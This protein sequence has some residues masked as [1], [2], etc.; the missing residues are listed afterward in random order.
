MSKLIANF[1]CNN[2][3]AM[4][5]NKEYPATHSMSTAWFAADEDGNVAIIDFDENGPVPQVAEEEGCFMSVFM[6]F[7]FRKS[8]KTPI[9]YLNFTKAQVAEFLNNPQKKIKI[10]KTEKLLFGCYVKIKKDEQKNFIKLLSRKKTKVDVYCLSEE[11]SIYYINE[12]SRVSKNLYQTIEKMWDMDFY[13]S[14]EYSKQTDSIDYDLSGCKNLP[15]YLFLQPYY[16]QKFPIQHLITPKHPV[17]VSQMPKFVANSIIRLPIKFSETNFLELPKYIPTFCMNEDTTD[18]ALEVF[19]NEKYIFE[20]IELPD[21]NGSYAYYLIDSIL[22][23]QK[24]IPDIRESYGYQASFSPTILGIT[25]PYRPRDWNDIYGYINLFTQ[26]Y[27]MLSFSQDIPD[28][29][30]EQFSPEEKIRYYSKSYIENNIRFF[31]PYLILIKD[32][33]KFVLE[34]YYKLENHQITINSQTFPY[35]LFSEME[36]HRDEILEYSNK[37]YRGIKIPTKLT[38]DEIESLKH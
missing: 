1:G 15:F 28:C 32:E 35:F 33:I 8:E 23:C 16:S 21:C 4:K 36:Q 25:E 17:K 13:F 18:I 26:Q 24:G 22:R 6:D 31:N 7:F 2:N 10:D 34:H 38:K 30:G 14:N 5:T 19:P 37:E 27:V 3:Y 29:S 11:E 9:K 12:I 20:Y